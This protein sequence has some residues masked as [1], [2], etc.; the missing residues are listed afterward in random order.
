MRPIWAHFYFMVNIMIKLYFFIGTILAVYSAYLAGIHTGTHQCQTENANA[1][2]SKI[3]DT[4]KTMGI[5]NAKTVNT[6]VDD[7]RRILREKYTIAE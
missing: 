4:I 7:I 2:A 1:H 3:N 5:I 6:G